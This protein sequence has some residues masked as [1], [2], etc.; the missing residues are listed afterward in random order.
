MTRIF[1]YILVHDHGLAPCPANGLVTLATCKPSIRRSAAVGDWVLGFR[2]GSLERGLLLWG[3]RVGQVMDH[4]EYERRH[5]GRPDALYHERP[6]GGY[7]RLDP[8]YH[9]SEA[10]KARDLSGPVLIFDPLV[11]RHLGGRPLPLPES[12]MHLAAAGR[13]HRVNGVV[14]GDVERLGHWFSS[15]VVPRGMHQQGASTRARTTRRRC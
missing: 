4:G 2:P 6:D 12:L 10:E 11:S 14:D 13:G 5:R 7:D 9:P 1:R 15:E 8:D 3:G